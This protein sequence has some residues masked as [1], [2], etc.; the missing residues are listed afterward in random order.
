M[1]TRRRNYFNDHCISVDLLAAWNVYELILSKAIE[2][3]RRN[4]L[5]KVLSCVFL[6]V[7]IKKPDK[8]HEILIELKDR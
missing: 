5:K 4:A 3:K 7:A 8:N 1:E 6:F 2:E